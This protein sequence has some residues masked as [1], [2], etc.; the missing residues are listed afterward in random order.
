MRPDARYFLKKKNYWAVQFY[1]KARL[2]EFISD[3]VLSTRA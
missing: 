1:S 3:I 2:N